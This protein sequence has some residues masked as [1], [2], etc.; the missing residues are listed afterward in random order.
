[1]FLLRLTTIIIFFWALCLNSA[2][3]AELKIHNLTI[4]NSDRMILIKGIGNYKTQSSFYIPVADTK[5]NTISIINSI[6]NTNAITT[7]TL[8]NPKRYVIDIP[9]ATLI[10][11]KRSYEYN[12]SKKIKNIRLSQFSINPNI[13][14]FV[15]EAYD[16][17]DLSLFKTYT[18]GKNIVVKYDSNIIDNSIQYK[19]Y[20]PT[21]DGD[22]GAVLQNTSAKIVYNDNPNVTQ[23]NPQLQAKYMLSRV[24]Q[25]SNGLILRGIGSLSMQRIIYKEDLKQAELILDNAVLSNKIEN[26]TYDIP[27]QKA[28]L[29]IERLN[30]KK[31]KLTLK[32]ENYKDF[33][34]IVSPDGQS[35]FVSD[36]TFIINTAFS[37]NPAKT[38]SYKLNKTKTD[39]TL[40]T[41]NFDKPVAY[42]V[43]ELNDN[44]YLDI[45]NLSDYNI[46][47]FEQMLK[48]QD[49]KI[50]ALKISND[51]TRFIIPVSNLNFSY[52]NV[53]SN[54]KSITLCFKNKVV[55]QK[56]V[57][58]EKIEKIETKKD[59]NNI[60]YIPKEEDL[61][62]KKVEKPKKKKENLSISA[63]R[64]VVI[65]PGHGGSDTGAVN[66]KN[67][68]K[69][70]NLIVA[71]LVYD[72]L[73]KKNIYVHMTRT[74][75][76][77]MSLEERVNFSNELSPDIFVSIHTNSTV[78]KDPMGLETHYFK[79]D[80]YK[81]AQTIHKHFASE[82]N[83]NKWQTKDRGV[84]KSRFYV[85]NHTE[86]PSI[87]IEMGFISNDKEL[88]KL[89]V[90]QRQQEIADSIVKGILEYLKA[91]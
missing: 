14:R 6:T 36:R 24:T 26:K 44:F 15:V 25:G 64:K 89:L 72:K 47:A 40:F 8:T 67:Y 30:E 82:K 87:L 33:R 77:S 59:N 60:V 28:T 62:K 23:I 81:L 18:N 88:A 63:M 12:N 69:T 65:D 74:K 2:C 90:K 76:V 86:A 4:D 49:L 56:P 27:N 43:F 57:V 39:Y 22:K 73:I 71:K 70:L 37:A 34:Y 21:G 11:P 20:T 3:F 85:I 7:S 53:E 83:V 79:D 13:V 46:G 16:E 9:N 80:S 29:S 32:A 19:F 31:I 61:D 78:A 1:M 54:A 41:I 52:A 45:D 5:T 48:N 84:I 58:V 68:E 35:L 55:E 50:E 17:A 66:N 38:L 75:D 91:K 51:K 42:N 10:G